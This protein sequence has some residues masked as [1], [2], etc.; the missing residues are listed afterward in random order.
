MKTEVQRKIAESFPQTY[1]ETELNIELNEKE[2]ELFK[3]GIFA[4]GMDEKWNIFTMDKSIYFSR[5]WTD[6]CIFKAGFEKNDGK[7]IINNLKVSRDEL[8]YKS[9]DL[10][11]DSNLFKK[12]LEIYLNRKDLYVDERIKIPLI[13]KT[14]KKYEPNY[15]IQN[16]IGCQS[17]ELNIQ[18]YDSLRK[19]SSH[20]IEIIGF[21]KLRKKVAELKADYQLLSLHLSKKDNSGKSITIFFNQNGTELIGII[22]RIRKKAS[23]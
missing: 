3:N 21:E 12:V 17:V 23:G 6:N 20:I 11:Y 1:A 9:T 4:S 13:Q 18:I 2:I 22:E 7:T 16:Y 19:S 8:Q 10:D 15:E 5:S 14:I